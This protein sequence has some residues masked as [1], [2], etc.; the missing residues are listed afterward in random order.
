MANTV[1]VR[2]SIYAPLLD[3]MRIDV[4]WLGENGIW[5]PAAYAP[6]NLRRTMGPQKPNIPLIT[7]SFHHPTTPLVQKYFAS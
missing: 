1:P 7:S 4:N 5:Q 2:F 6:F 3:V